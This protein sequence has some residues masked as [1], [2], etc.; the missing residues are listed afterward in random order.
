MTRN[1]AQPPVLGTLLVAVFAW[2]GCFAETY[3]AEWQGRGMRLRLLVENAVGPSWIAWDAE[4]LP[5]ADLVYVDVDDWDVWVMDEFGG[6]RSCLTRP[7][8]N[9]LG[10]DFPLDRDDDSPRTHWKGDPEAHPT[11]PLILFKAENEHSRHRALRNAPSI[12]WDNDLWALNVETRKYTRLTRLA[13]GEGL[14]HS[15]WS[16]DGVWYVYPHRYF[17]GDPPGDFGHVRMVF[18]AFVVDG[19]GTPRLEKRF[20]VEPQGKMYYEP[21]DIRRNDDG[22]HTLLYVAGAGNILDP[23]RYDWTFE[24]GKVS[25]RARRLQDTPDLHEEFTSFSPAGD[26]IV[27]M[28]GPLKRYAY[29]ADLYES[30]PDFTDVK[31]LTWF[32]D[33]DVWPEM[34]RTYGAQL[35]RL[36]WKGDGTAVFFGVWTH[37]PVLPF[38]KTHLYRL[39][40]P[41]D[42]K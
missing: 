27:W 3:P 11:K 24:G 16:D 34:G 13:P 25:G 7:G 6:N 41:P 35:S 17:F 15:A 39:D 29:R 2:T 42:R 14:Q 33:R 37:G 21:I 9:A 36:D 38:R 31:R 26:R 22:S 32:N 18:N 20:A 23:Y 19:E 1:A 40:L 4:T 8:R 28:R 12:G 30:K 5:K 10:V